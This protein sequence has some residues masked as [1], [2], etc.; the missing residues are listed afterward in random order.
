MLSPLTSAGTVLRARSAG[1]GSPGA[2]PGRVGCV[3]EGELVRRAPIGQHDGPAAVVGGR[4][5]DGPVD[6]EVEPAV[7]VEVRRDEAVVLATL[8]PIRGDAARPLAAISTATPVPETTRS[9][10]P[11]P[12]AEIRPLGRRKVSP[13]TG[14]SGVIWRGPPLGP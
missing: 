11:S 5:A 3:G 13:P 2:V 10:Q 9:R 1:R 14:S 7:A 8:R 12:S 6:D 4:G